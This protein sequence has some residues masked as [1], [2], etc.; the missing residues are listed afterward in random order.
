MIVEKRM[1]TVRFDM[2]CL[3]GDGEENCI[4]VVAR[5]GELDNSIWRE[6]MQSLLGRY[7]Y[8]YDDGV[9]YDEINGAWEQHYFLVY[10]KVIVLAKWLL[11]KGYSSAKLDVRYRVHVSSPSIFLP[12]R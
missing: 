11:C 6:R 5:C 4:G 12:R 8:I 2:F 10:Q 1:L 3:V 7:R 9:S